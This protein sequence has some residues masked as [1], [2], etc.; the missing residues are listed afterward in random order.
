MRG[1]RE[2]RREGGKERE[3]ALPGSVEALESRIS[4]KPNLLSC[5]VFLK[6][7]IRAGGR[8]ESRLTAPGNCHLMDG[9]TEGQRG[10]WKAQSKHQISKGREEKASI[11]E[12]EWRGQGTAGSREGL[13]Q[14]CGGWTVC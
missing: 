1:G 14:K 6:P 2:G 11:R 13:Q 12:A 7:E 9:N 10:P 8:W 3:R 4:K 5:G